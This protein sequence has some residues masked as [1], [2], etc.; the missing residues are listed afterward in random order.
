MIG[1]EKAAVLKILGYRLISGRSRTH[2]YRA[3]TSVISVI[4]VISVAKN[5][6]PC[7]QKTAEKESHRDHR[8]HGG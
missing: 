8:D 1:R 4:S 5:K 3:S 7:G 2:V 6:R